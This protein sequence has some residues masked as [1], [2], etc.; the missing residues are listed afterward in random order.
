MAK[1]TTSLPNLPPPY[2]ADEVHVPSY[3]FP[4]LLSNNSPPK[5]KK[6]RKKYRKV[7][8]IKN[9]NLASIIKKIKI[10]VKKAARDFRTEEVKKEVSKVLPYLVQQN[11]EKSMLI[12]LTPKNNI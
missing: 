11:I 6:P 2:K 3:L 9:E 5:M 12:R 8:N 1:S 4:G 7:T 10:L